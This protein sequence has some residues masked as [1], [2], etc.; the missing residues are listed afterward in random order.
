MNTSITCWFYGWGFWY[1][2]SFK[3][4]HESIKFIFWEWAIKAI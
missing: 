2:K 4:Y 3:L 1:H